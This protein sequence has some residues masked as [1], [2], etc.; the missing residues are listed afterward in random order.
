MWAALNS[1]LLM[2]NNL[3]IISASAFT[4]LNNPAVIAINQ[5]PLAKSAIR[6]LRNTNVAKDRYGM[7]ETQVWSG[8]LY[9]GDRVVIMLNAA[10]ED[11]E[12]S[13]TL[14]EIFI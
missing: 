2:G 14:E 1:P 11:I 8:K 6:V 12:I 13:V 7:G 5:D 10:A 4:I 3:R 9:G